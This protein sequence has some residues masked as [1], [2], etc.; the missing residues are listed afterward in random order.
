MGAKEF[1]RFVKSESPCLA[2]TAR[3]DD[4][5]FGCLDTVGPQANNIARTCVLAAGVPESVP[6]TTIDRQCGSSQQAV[7]FAAQA[8][9]CWLRRFPLRGWRS[10]VAG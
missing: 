4:V 7:Q 5:I 1:G 3:F 2:P 6:A 9:K 8:V 10:S